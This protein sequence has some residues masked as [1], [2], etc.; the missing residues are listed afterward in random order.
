MSRERIA[1]IV[2]VVL[3]V[4]VA[5]WFQFGHAPEPKPK[6]QPPAQPMAEPTLASLAGPVKPWVRLTA[7]QDH[8]RIL[9]E[10]HLAALRPG[11]SG[12]P[13]APGAA[14]TDEA[15]ANP[16]PDLP[17]PLKLR[18]GTAVTSSDMWWQQRRGELAETLEAEVYGKQRP[19]ATIT[20]TAD[21]G[22]PEQVGAVA[23][24]TRHVI[25]RV[26]GVQNL[27][28]I[29][30]TA[31]LTVTIP[32]AAKGPV[33]V[34]LLLTSSDAERRAASTWREQ[35]LAKGWG[36]AV[37]DV[38]SLQPD[39][40]AGLTSGAIG[41]STGGQPRRIDDWGVLRAWAWGAS[42][43]LDYLEGF[44][45]VDAAQVGIAGHSRYGKAALVAMAYDARFVVAYISSSGAG[46]AALM[47][48]HFGEQIENLAGTGEYHWFGGSF[49]K[50][51]GTLTAK[52]LPV[53]SHELIAL[54][55]PRPIFI[56][57]GSKGDDW[58][59]PRGMFMAEA[60]ATPVYK[61]MGKT[62][63]SA[64]AMPAP[65]TLVDGGE[66]AFRQHEQGHTMEPNWPY[67]LKFAERYLH[68]K[69]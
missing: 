33:P 59:D 21:G 27:P 24:V 2:S 35:V 37:F 3:V 45:K 44:D 20:W 28:W 62:G 69:G 63:L 39:N 7:A 60:A 42:R 58:V 46:G 13:H 50:Y 38:T 30:T 43:V 34:I 31:Q 12:D 11:V 56:S 18:D 48:R 41:L 40:G 1:I 68:T 6:P 53:D 64:T 51:A 55:A 17:D 32:A 4:A 36:A 14:N 25:G 57:A 54:A 5:L 8:A 22:K 47:R 16:Y 15:K 10:L 67:F 26:Y 29:T 66:L 23:A 65:G 19:E 9:K 49:L 52:D 61:L